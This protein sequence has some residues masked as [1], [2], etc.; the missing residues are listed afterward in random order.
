MLGGKPNCFADC[1]DY[2]QNHTLKKVE[3]MLKAVSEINGQIIM[4]RLV[5]FFTWDFEDM[6]VTYEEQCGGII[7]AESEERQS[8][9]LA[10]ANR[11]LERRLRDF[12]NFNIDIKG[13]EKKFRDT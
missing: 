2:K 4:Q 11:R 7:E 9:S 6:V 3:V 10:N 1:I 8:I 12:K 13:K 5:S